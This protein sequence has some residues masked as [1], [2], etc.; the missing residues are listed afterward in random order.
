MNIEEAKA[1]ATKYKWYLV[2]VALL[3]IFSLFAGVEKSVAHD[4]GWQDGYIQDETHCVQQPMADANG[5]IT[6][7]V[8]CD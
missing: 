7:V 8:V 2:G 6:Y 3:I 1:L 5:G 4:C